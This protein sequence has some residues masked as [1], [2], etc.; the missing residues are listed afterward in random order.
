MRIC[1]SFSLQI[2]V[3]LQPRFL[4]LKGGGVLKADT[5]I[6]LTMKIRNTCKKTSISIVTGR[7]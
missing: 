7:F 3:F 1:K 2:Y 4:G 5:V 6:A